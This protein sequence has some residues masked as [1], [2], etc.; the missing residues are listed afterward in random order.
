MCRVNCVFVDTPH[1]LGI[2]T[3]TDVLDAIV[4]ADRSL[5]DPVVQIATVPIVTCDSQAPLFQALVSMTRHRIERVAVTRHGQL[6][7][8]LGGQ[9]GAGGGTVLQQCRH[10]GV[11]V[12]DAGGWRQQGGRG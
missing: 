9:A 7:G 3:R 5:S 8:T 10:V 2:A 4:L 6:V 12:D 1:E 11:A